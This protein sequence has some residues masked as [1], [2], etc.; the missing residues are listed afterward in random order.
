MESKPGE[1]VV[2]KEVPPGLLD[3]LPLEDQ[4]AIVEVVGKSNAASEL[5]RLDSCR[6][7][8]CI[9]RF[10]LWKLKTA[11]LAV[12]NRI[13][14]ERLLLV[15]FCIFLSGCR[16]RQDLLGPSIEFT[17]IP[18]AAVGGLDNM[19]TI[20]G[21]VKS[22]RPE[23]RV[24]LYAKSEGR[25]WI[26]PFARDPLFTKIRGDSKWKNVTHLGE[27]YAA[28]LV[29][30]SYSP[31]QSTEVLPAAGSPVAAVAVVKGQTAD[32]SSPPKM[33]HFSGYDWLVRNLLSY[34]GG[35]MNSFDPANAWT[36]ENG[37]LHLH[38]TKNQDGWSCAELK[39]T[40]SLGYGTYLFVVR[41]ISHLEPSAVLSLFTWDGMG[42]DENRH[43]LDIEVSHWGWPNNENAQYVVQPYYIPTSTVRF[44]VP[45]GVVTHA[46]RW[47]PG[48]VTFTTYSGA[49]LTGRA[50]PL[51]QHVF[52]AHVPVPGGEVV[53]INLYVL[54]WGKVPLQRENEI[55]VEK[56]KYYP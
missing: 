16:A 29:D 56:F 3:D 26:Q 32:P 45:A 4:Q 21:R 43:E 42:T 36:D 54:G 28:L 49:Q 13:A 10:D 46:F 7:R 17:K 40:R 23:Q 30:P 8:V 27:A 50:H 53:R 31:P 2:L 1:W 35:S 52:T 11:P 38:V 24:V 41:D 6:K 34:R 44:N 25:W 18:V 22:V 37:A 51:N 48:Q 19:D 9:L 5:T 15:I 39:L 47:E 14:R 33:I 20:E 12:L 55:V